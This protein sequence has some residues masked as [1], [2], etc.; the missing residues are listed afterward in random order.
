MRKS[1]VAAAIMAVLS[2]AMPVQAAGLSIKVGTGVSGDHPENVGAREIKRLIESRSGGAISVQ[3]FTDNQLGNQRE[4]VEQLRSGVLELTWVTT[5]FFGSWEPVMN[6]LEIGYLFDDADHAFRV[7]DGPLKPEIAALIGK[8][9][10]RL[11]G[12][13]DAGI[14]Q[15]TNNVRPINGPA[16]LAGLKIRTPQSIY[17][18]K[19]M[20]L[21][22]VSPTPMAFNELYSAME[23]GVVDGQENPISNIHSAKFFE[24]NKHIAMTGHLQLVHMVMYSDALWQKLTPAQR[25]IIEKAVIDSQAVQRAKVR[26]DD[27]KL[28]VELEKRG[29]RVTRPDRAAFA[30][31]VRPLRGEATTAYGDQ[32]ARWLKLIDDNR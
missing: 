26:A 32:A 15:L 3:V 29:M 23:Q 12:F 5:G 18:M 25:D 17:H 28:L 2:L 13:Y 10:A 22:G 21:M 9:G 30:K 11:L 24:V 20:A 16:D 19:T 27:E 4:M 6:S 8:H 7:F 14:R 1:F 31:L